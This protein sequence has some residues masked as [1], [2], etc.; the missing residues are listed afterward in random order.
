M[1]VG[2]NMTPKRRFHILDALIFVASTA[3]GLAWSAA[4]ARGWWKLSE[5]DA[6]NA[7]AFG[8]FFTFFLLSWTLAFPLVRIRSP[9]QSVRRLG[10]S[11]GTAAC[12]TVLVVLVLN[13]VEA[14]TSWVLEV[15]W[16]RVE[17]P[18]KI[19]EVLLGLS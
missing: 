13:L 1:V 4:W 6:I 14:L 2:V 11:P 12:L 16:V 3:V 19:S 15:I 18:Q 7:Q 10:R 8:R 17:D 9:R 5:W